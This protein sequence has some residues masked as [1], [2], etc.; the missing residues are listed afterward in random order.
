VLSYYVQASVDQL[1]MH[2]TSAVHNTAFTKILGYAELCSGTGDGS[3]QKR[4]YNDL[5][6]VNTVILCI[7]VWAGCV[8]LL[9]YLNYCHLY[10]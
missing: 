6:T 3:F 10:F 8:H 9:W 4:Q 5:C 7:V 1:L 2:F